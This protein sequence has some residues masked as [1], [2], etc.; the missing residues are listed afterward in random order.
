MQ[1]N[2][3][4]AIVG[5]CGSGKSTFCKWLDERGFEGVYFGEITLKEIKKQQLELTPKNEKLMREKLREEH[6]MDA[7]AK[8]SLPTIRQLL[9]KGSVYV[10]GLYSYEE[11]QLLVQT[12]PKILVVEVFADKSIRYDRLKS[13]PKRPLTFEEAKARDI[14]EIEKLNKAPP[15]ALSDYK[16][17]NNGD[18][19]ALARNAE[20][21]LDRMGKK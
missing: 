2:V 5:M 18:E 19:K 16:L 3:I 17:P 20:D 13:R 6:G 8:L 14:S 12:F 11:L 7:F 9:E 4:I 10:D 21:L 1:S 15:I